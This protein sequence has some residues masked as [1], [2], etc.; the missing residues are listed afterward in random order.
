[1]G[2]GASG[3]RFVEL[4]GPSEQISG[5]DGGSGHL[6]RIHPRRMVSWNVGPGEAAFRSEDLVDDFK[7]GEAEPAHPALGLGGAAHNEATAAVDLLVGEL[8]SGW[9]HRDADIS[10]RH[11]AADILWGSP[12]GA[13]VNSYDDL[14][15]IHV[16]L[17]EEGRGGA[18]SRFDV[19]RVLAPVPGVAVAQVRRVALDTDGQ[20]SEA[21]TDVTG[22]FSELVLY[23]LVRRRGGWWLAAG[24]NTPIRPAL[25][26]PQSPS[27]CKAVDCFALSQREA[28]P[29]SA[30]STSRLPEE[31][32]DH[33]ATCTGLT[34]EH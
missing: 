22:S 6:I 9:D 33:A 34:A 31:V 19:I 29:N 32:D 27:T 3:M 10:N 21:S 4:R 12:F 2:E 7:I 8:Q 17:K 14:H 13:T 16:R 28:A 24:Q 25:Q 30:R 26:T 15:A 18:S 1:V 11:F 20:P 5:D 23:V